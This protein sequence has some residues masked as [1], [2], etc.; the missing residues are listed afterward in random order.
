MFV[1]VLV[2]IY[3]V[4]SM[5]P[6]IAALTRTAVEHYPSQEACEADG[7][8]QLKKFSSDMPQNPVAFLAKCVEVT[9]PAGQKA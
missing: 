2:A 7:A 8:K 6:P 9:G 4:S 3:F 5:D 1:M